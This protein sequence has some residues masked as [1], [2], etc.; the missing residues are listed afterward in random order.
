[1]EEMITYEAT[2]DNELTDGVYA[3]SLVNSPAI[4]Q[5]FIL[6]DKDDK[7]KIEIM[8]EKIIDEKRHIV[9][10]P[11]LIP[12]KIIP[13]KNKNIVFRSDTIRKIA[14]NFLMN[15]K[16]D[17]V[18]LQHALNVNKVYMIES[19]IVEDSEKDKSALY[20]YNLPVGSW[21]GAYKIDDLDLWNEYIETGVLRGFSLEGIFTEVPVNLQMSTEDI[22]LDKEILELI[23]TLNYTPKDLDSYYMWK[24]G[25]G[26]KDGNCPAC[27][28]LS[29]KIYTLKQWTKIAIP[30]HKNGT[31]IAGV[32]CSF[33]HDPFGTYCQDKCTCRLVKVASKDFIKKTIK[34]PF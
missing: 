30:G 24:L 11:I 17:N 6:L 20:G 29:N 2:I 15:G 27:K 8:L 14:E 13:R 16:K 26:T 25:P 3:I 9:L 18:T 34:K 28:E 5:D 7:V 22:E 10:G 32:V 33:P 4:Q 12:D 31:N 19:W 21:F 23:A 1:M